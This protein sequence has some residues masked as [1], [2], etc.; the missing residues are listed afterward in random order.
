MSPLVVVL[1]ELVALPVVWWDGRG[2]CAVFPVLV[3]VPLPMLRT[4]A[5][6]DG[7]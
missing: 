6:S 1:D 2:Y 5:G 3:L 7:R 4:R